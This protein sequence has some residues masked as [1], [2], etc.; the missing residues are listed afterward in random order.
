MRF[1]QVDPLQDPRWPRLVE[2]HPKASVFH[3]GA[4]LEALHRSYS[5]RPVAFTTSQP[6][7]ELENGL[8]FCHV[9]SWLTGGR[10]VSLPFSDHCEPLF[11]SKEELRFVMQCLQADLQHRKWKYIELRPANG[12]VGPDAPR[13]GF[14]PCEQYYLHRMDLRPN[15]NEIFQGLH[16]DSAQRRIRHAVTSGVSC[17]C[18]R[19]SRL[20]KD[21]YGLL[22]STRARHRLPP[23]PLLWFRNLISSMKDAL[24]IRVAYKECVPVAAI[25]TLRFRETVYYKYGCSN[26]EFKHL[27]AMPYLFWHAIEQSKSAGALE[28]DLGR[29]DRD[30][31]GLV[32]FKNHWA[33]RPLDLIYWAY[34]EPPSTK[35]WKMT[36]A[37]RAFSWMPDRLLAATG[38]VIYR[39]FA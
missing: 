15:L 18:G 8:L 30:N 25:L 11:D 28:F 39:H 2:Q 26:L 4:W 13:F 3:T 6:N 19:S 23:Q 14:Q 5:Y 10:M 36:V 16:K 22:V 31:T 35:G 34:P 38:T 33:R 21:F 7:E 9:R 37:R 29:S 27:G 12:S 20:L 24:E 1:H 32:A 17:E